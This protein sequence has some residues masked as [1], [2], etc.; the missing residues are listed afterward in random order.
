[1]TRGAAS[2]PH[3]LC[4]PSICGECSEAVHFEQ[5]ALHSNVSLEQ[6]ACGPG[7]GMH[8]CQ[9]AVA[10]V[11]PCHPHAPASA[12]L[13]SCA[14]TPHAHSGYRAPCNQMYGHMRSP[15]GEGWDVEASTHA[16]QAVTSIT[17]GPS[18]ANTPSA[19][20]HL[21]PTQQS[22]PAERV[23]LI[24]EHHA[25]LH[26]ARN[27]KREAHQLLRLAAAHRQEGRRGPQ[28]C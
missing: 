24:D 27:L 25:G 15:Q 22:A 13:S 14:V 28:R 21:R 8:F 1:M 2:P 5:G 23:D 19:V 4:M 11:P 10:R 17:I 9:H 16:Y 18:A 26:R 6:W 12:A 20:G 3:P 7:A